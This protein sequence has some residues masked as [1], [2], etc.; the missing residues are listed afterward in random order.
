MAR[1]LKKIL[2]SLEAKALRLAADRDRLQDE[3]K[4]LEEE[5]RHIKEKWGGILEENRRLELE[6]EFLKVSHRLASDPD[7]LVEARRHVAR[8]IRIVDKCVA[9]LREDPKL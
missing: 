4:A 6:V 5:L 7:T 9:M 8:L 2:E 1:D 3:K